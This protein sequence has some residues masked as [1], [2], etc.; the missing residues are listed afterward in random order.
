MKLIVKSNI[1]SELGL[2]A[3]IYQT[4]PYRKDKLKKELRNMAESQNYESHGLGKTGTRKQ[5]FKIS[6]MQLYIMNL[7]N[8]VFKDGSRNN[9]YF[10]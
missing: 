7:Q 5:P 8:L 10:F 1:I 4:L 9:R 2:A 3:V 6:S